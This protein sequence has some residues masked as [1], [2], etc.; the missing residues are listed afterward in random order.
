MHLARDPRLR[1]LE[2]GRQVAVAIVDPDREIA[3][4]VFAG[5]RA[6]TLAH[7]QLGNIG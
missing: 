1:R 3:F 5:D 7:T 2:I 6:L 4:A